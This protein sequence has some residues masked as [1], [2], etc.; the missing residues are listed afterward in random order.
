MK[1]KKV[2]LLVCLILFI[3]SAWSQKIWTV[4]QAKMWY[5]QQPWLVG[6]NFIPSSAINELEMWQADTWDP[7]TIDRE[8]G[9]A[10]SI[11]FNVVRVYLHNLVWEAD[12][13]AFKKRINEF[14]VIADRHNL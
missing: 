14:L 1:M 6:C 7:K 13:E 12:A 5:T 11:G 4:D 8:L 10:E 2:S 3:S 9:W